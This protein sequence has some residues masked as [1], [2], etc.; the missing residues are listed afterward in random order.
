MQKRIQTPD[1]LKGFAVI[2][3]I[4]V[5]IMELFARQELYDGWAGKL[6]LFLGG[7]PAAP[8]FMIIMGYFLAFGQKEPIKMMMRGVKLFM[9]GM[10]LNIG[11]NAHLI[12]TVLNDGWQVNFWHYIFGVDIFHLAGLSLMVI[13]LIN[14]LYKRHFLPYIITAIGIVVISSVVVPFSNESNT[15]TYLM[16]FI[17]SNSEW[18]YFPLIPWLA[19]PL[20]GYSFKLFEE[21]YLKSGLNLKIRVSLTVVL[22]VLFLFTVNYAVGISHNLDVYYHHDAVFYC[23][24]LSFVILWAMKS[25][26]TE[27][28]AGNAII[29]RYVKWLGINVTIVYIIQWLIIGNIATSIYK[30]QG[31]TGF[32]FWFVGITIFT[33][34][35][36]LLWNKIK[37]VFNLNFLK[38]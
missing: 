15:G 36:T 32:I 13:A 18:S 6:S 3:M 10:V 20:T 33:S 27:K 8:V 23:W 1:L 38:L 26:L 16:A 28:V 29:L 21:K 24:A 25:S 7:V 5:H 31:L 19:Y 34:L 11:L 17:H 12:Y 22:A 2:F 37:S 30:T 4:Q 9:A 35:L 14:G